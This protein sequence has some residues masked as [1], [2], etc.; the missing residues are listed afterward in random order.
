MNKLI[1]SAALTGAGTS[2]EAAPTVPYHADERERRIP[3]IRRNGA[4]TNVLFA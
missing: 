3:L 2:K 1:I 4:R